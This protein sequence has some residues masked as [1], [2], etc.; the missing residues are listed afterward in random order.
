MVRRSKMLRKFEQLSKIAKVPGLE[1]MLASNTVS[2]LR[3]EA[4]Q[5]EASDIP[6]A[7]IAKAAGC[8]DLYTGVYATLSSSAHSSVHDI[9]HR[10]VYSGDGRIETFSKASNAQDV[11]FI[12]VGAIEILLDTSLAACA[13]L[14][15]DCTEYLRQEHDILREL[16]DVTVAATGTTPR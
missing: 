15:K 10:I 11:P 1:E 5:V 13:F 9:E 4:A 16:A 8:Y 14:D 6:I 3:E 12:L 7:E 2:K